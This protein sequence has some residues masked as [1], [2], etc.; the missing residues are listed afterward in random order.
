MGFC[1]SNYLQAGFQCIFVD[2]LFF[3]FVSASLNVHVPTL[4]T[5]SFAVRVWHFLKSRQVSPKSTVEDFE[6]VTC[7][8]IFVSK[9]DFS[10]ILSFIL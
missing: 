1:Y 6:Y 9:H 3:D 10:I 5:L 4:M 2:E 7:D 8:N